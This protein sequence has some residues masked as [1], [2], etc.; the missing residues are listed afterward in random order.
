MSVIT[1]IRKLYPLQLDD[2]S[3]EIDFDPADGAPPL[4]VAT[5]P[6]SGSAPSPDAPPPLVAPQ[7][8]TS[9]SAAASGTNTY[10]YTFTSS[11]N[12][13][14][15]EY[16]YSSGSQVTL[17]WKA[18]VSGQISISGGENQTSSWQ[19]TISYSG[20][21]NPTGQN[22]DPSDSNYVP[23]STTSNN[24]PAT[25]NISSSGLVLAGVLLG[26]GIGTGDSGVISFSGNLSGDQ[27]QITGNINISDPPLG[28]YRQN[29]R[30]FDLR[31]VHYGRQY[32]RF[33]RTDLSTSPGH[34]CGRTALQRDGWKR[35]GDIAEFTRWHNIQARPPIRCARNSHWYRLG[36]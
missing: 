4:A 34:Q 24:N 31:A 11:Y 28:D 25:A 15:T 6:N 5:L 1:V 8:G 2:P 17:L 16:D 20:T 10:T 21:P 3:L 36:S 33:Y 35:H 12:T 23:F 32:G 29:P 18:S 22:P 7:V 9:A 13:Q 30:N 14:F 19:C 26:S 27:T